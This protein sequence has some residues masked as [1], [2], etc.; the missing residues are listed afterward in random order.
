MCSVYGIRLKYNLLAFFVVVAPACGDGDAITLEARAYSET[1]V[2]RT[3]LIVRLSLRNNSD[4]TIMTAFPPHQQDLLADHV[5][6]VLRDEQGH[7][8][9]LTY[10]GGPWI[11]ATALTPSHPLNPGDVRQ[12]DRLVS[13][14]VRTPPPPRWAGLSVERYKF[15]P[16]GSY[17]GYFQLHLPHGKKLV[18]NEFWLTILEAKGIDA[19]ARDSV[20]FGHAGFLEGREAGSTEYY[21]RGG[22]T[23]DGVDVSRFK[24][25]QDILDDFPDSPYAEW[26]RFWKLYHHGPVENALQYAR[27]HPDFPLSDNLMLHMAEGLF[28]SA[29]KHD[30]ATYDRVRE[31]VA[32][33]L[34]DFPDGDTRAQTLA[35]KE[36]L[37]K[38]P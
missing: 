36:K 4:A 13:L 18:S 31:L 8:F 15:L 2:E 26:I 3:P 17:G 5:S 23:R 28:H 27:E 14:I 29:T 9:E 16:P 22:K 11:C 12:V 33:L 19:M 10:R 25:L 6:L 32:E 38:K 34:R 24:E 7:V 21:R 30:R 20:E 1:V 37:T 35:L